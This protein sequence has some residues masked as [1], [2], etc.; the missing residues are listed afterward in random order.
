MSETVIYY[1]NQYSIQEQWSTN[2]GYMV[3]HILTNYAS[4]TTDGDIQRLVTNTCPGTDLG[5]ISKVELQAYAYSDA[6][7][8]LILRPVFVALDGDDH[9]EAPGVTPGWKT[10]WD[11]TNDPNAPS[12]W[13]WAAVESL[14]CDV[15]QNDVAKGNTMHVSEVQIRVTYTPSGPPTYYHGLKIQGEDELALC[16]V[17]THPLR[18]CKGGTVYAIELVAVDDPNASRIRIKTPAGVKAIRKYT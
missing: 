17:G 4:T 14:D 7:D 15:E 11:I 3:D 8:Q 18:T 16:D 5:T 10:W 12:P 9:I 13:T 2:P 6:D 1:F